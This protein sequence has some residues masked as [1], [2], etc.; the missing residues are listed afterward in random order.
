MGPHGQYRPASPK[1]HEALRQTAK[2]RVPSNS[3]TCTLFAYFLR[4]G[5]DVLN[6]LGR[7]DLRQRQVRVVLMGRQR[8][9]S[10]REHSSQLFT[11]VPSTN[12][13]LLTGGA[14][15]GLRRS[16]SSSTSRTSSSMCSTRPM[17]STPQRPSAVSRQSLCGWMCTW[18]CA[19]APL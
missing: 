19:R 8:H 16:I 14:P 4:Q 18:A 5:I 15:G 17:K 2:A 6:L 1:D 12:K 7:L 9:G 3:P 10:R 13:G 11:F